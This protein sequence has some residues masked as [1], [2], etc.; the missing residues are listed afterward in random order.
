MQSFAEL[1]SALLADLQIAD[2]PS[3]FSDMDLA[4]ARKVSLLSSFLKKNEESTSPAAD[5]A[6]LELFLDCNSRCANFKLEAKTLFHD[7]VIGEVKHILD[8]IFFS[9]PDHTIGS[10]DFDSLIGVG[11]GASLGARS[12]NFYTKLFDSP[13]S[14]TDDQLPVLYR[15]AISSNPTWLIAEKQRASLYG[16]RVVEGNRLSYVPKTTKVSRSICTEPSLNMLFQRGLGL[17]FEQLLKRHFSIDLSVQPELNRGLARLGS[18]DGSF[19]TIDLKSASDS[20]SL[21]LLNQILPRYVLAWLYRFRSPYTIL[22]D[23]TRLQLHMVSS[24]GNGFTF[25]LQTLLFATIVKA[26]YRVLGVKLER[27]KAGPKNY[28]VFGDDIIVRKDCYE[29]VVNC[30]GLFGFTVNDEKSF[31]VGPFRESCG[32]DY[33]RGADIRGVYVKKLQSKPDVYSAINRLMRWSSTSGVPL[34][35]VMKQLLPRV[36]Y[37]PV[38]W[39]ASDTEG[40][41]VPKARL[42]QPTC[43]ENG[44]IYYDALRPIAVG[45][46]APSGEA[47]K[48]MYYPGTRKT[49]I[50]F[51][52]N[53]VMVSLVGGY[54]RDGRITLRS[55]DSKTVRRFKIRRCK[56]PHWDFYGSVAERQQVHD[57]E[58]MYEMI[59]PIGSI[60]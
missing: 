9:G 6:C 11:P 49:R 28:G 29:F 25:P 45:F 23:G 58:V 37:L 21:N 19:G 33:F 48:P 52:E 26:C 7:E 4:T 24:M 20:V 53:G 57:W 30:L 40:I 44:C 5:A 1:R 47:K 39:H 15:R 42:V 17:V 16:F 18:L 36:R 27:S 51:N 10:I 13:L 14:Y 43:D 46:K 3:I 34:P 12:Y 22:P 55:E 32:G 54:I 41:K 8:D 60:N 31:N 35:T 59:F 56:T 50:E 38:P 2:N